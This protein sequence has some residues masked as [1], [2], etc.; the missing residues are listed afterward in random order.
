M[1][2]VEVVISMAVLSI[3]LV[4]LLQGAAISV[5]M[6]RSTA[7]QVAAESLARELLDWVCALPYDDPD[8]DAGPGLDAGELA[9]DRATFDD[10]DDF[11]GW[12]ETPPVRPDGVA[13][14]GFAAWERA[15]EVE[16]VDPAGLA[17]TAANDDRGAKRVSVSVWRSGK[18]LAQL[19]RVRYRA[20]DGAKQ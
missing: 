16:N 2:L 5:G 1:T 12:S 14:P 13:M 10:L 7:H 8:G 15:V 17:A 3:V 9:A 4:S 19:E 11:G 20:A 18:L 6:Q